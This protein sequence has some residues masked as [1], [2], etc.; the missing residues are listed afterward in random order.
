MGTRDLVGS[1]VT[2]RSVQRDFL[3]SY[4]KMFSRKVRHA[5][6]VTSLYAEGRYML[7]CAETTQAHFFYVI[8]ENTSGL[9]IGAI[10]IRNKDQYR[11]QLYGWLNE[12]F[13]GRGLYQ[14][15]IS[16]AAYHYF[17]STREPFFTACVDSANKR[18]YHALK[19]SG[20]AD[21]GVTNGP[22]GLQYKLL[23]RSKK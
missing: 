6:H 23:L 12:N 10:A 21:I 11:G 22:Y 3:T 20:F 5:L 1:L 19:K 2:L 16:L 8:F 4:C 9:L 13:W 15:A 18:G 7:A 14:Q 17:Q